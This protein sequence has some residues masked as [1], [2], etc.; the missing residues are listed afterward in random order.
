METIIVRA[1][2]TIKDDKNLAFVDSIIKEF[3]SNIKAKEPNTTM[4]RSFQVKETPCQFSHMIS[5]TDAVAEE[6]HRKTAY[7]KAFVAKLYPLCV[8][9]PVFTY[10]DEVM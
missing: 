4:Y 1:D 8:E 6:V 9:P 10:F 7:S 3:I 2:Y 5:F